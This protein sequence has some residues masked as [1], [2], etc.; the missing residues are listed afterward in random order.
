MPSFELMGVLIDISGAGAEDDPFI[1]QGVKDN[2][3]LAAL[4]E[5]KMV[6]IWMG[7][8][9]WFLVESRLLTPRKGQT[10]AVLKIRAFDSDD[11]LIQGEIWFDVSEAFR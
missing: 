10:M 7:E 8:G 5:H 1:V 11:Q 2:P 3:S 9:N 4:A 6:D